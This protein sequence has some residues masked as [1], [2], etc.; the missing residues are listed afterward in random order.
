MNIKLASSFLVAGTLML[1][2]AGHAADYK[3]DGA[4]APKTSESSEPSKASPSSTP[5]ASDSGSAKTY[6][7]DSVITGKVKAGLAEEKISSLA[8]LS[9]DTDNKGAVTL[10]GTAPDKSSADKAVTIARAV[11][12]VTSV[13]NDIKIKAD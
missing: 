10:S 6:A 11:T 9:V 8:K 13:R 12:G 2:L 3:S 5:M 7:K 1:P 4:M